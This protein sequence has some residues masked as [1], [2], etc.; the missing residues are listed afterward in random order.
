MLLRETFTEKHIRELQNSSRR[1]PI[2]LERAI[3]AFGLLE[4][5]ARVKMPFIFKGGTC[6]MLLTEHPQ[7]LSTDIDVIVQPG[8][9]LNE[10]L[11][12]ASEIFPFQHV[13]EQKRVGVNKIEKRHFK[14]TYNSPINN[15]PF[16]ILLDVLFAENYYEELI[17]KEIRNELLLSSPEY[18]TVSIPSADCI[19]ADKLTA[20]AP[21]TTG[22][23]LNDG[24]AMEVIKQLYDVCSLLD[25]VADF[26]NVHNTYKKIA[27][28]EIAYRG[29]AKT[30]DDC[31]NDTFEAALCV[32]SR[33]KVNA[34]AYPLYVRGIRNL[35]GHIYSE[36]YTPEIAAGR[37]VK[38]LLMVACLLTGTDYAPISDYREYLEQKITNEKL[39]PLQYL[40]KVN[41]EAYAYTVKTEGILALL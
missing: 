40:R 20:F 31:L 33:G 3:Y 30:P 4:A 18:L 14:F 28:A 22:I 15:R 5:L 7:R 37:A 34:E 35:R 29:I 36:N 32:A 8:T 12:K 17:I 11:N 24:R 1:D 2:L 21:N 26:R 27:Q 16:Y 19:L 13:E 10:Y 41:P 38:I 9:D 23:P 39:M 25:V 6:L